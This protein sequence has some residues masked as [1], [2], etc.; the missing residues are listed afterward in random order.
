MI[1]QDVVD[2]VEE[3]LIDEGVPEHVRDKIKDDVW[4]RLSDELEEG[5]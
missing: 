2:A 3:I 5:V 4:N 1:F